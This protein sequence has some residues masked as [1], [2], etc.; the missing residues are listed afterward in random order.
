MVPVPTLLL[1]PIELVLIEL[2]LIE[3]LLI[4]L[5][6][7]EFVPIDFVLI[8]FDHTPKNFVDYLIIVFKGQTPK[9]GPLGPLLY[10]EKFRDGV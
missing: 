4:E 3:L 2:V 6:P 10:V 1:V 8:E 5:L 7:I 9:L